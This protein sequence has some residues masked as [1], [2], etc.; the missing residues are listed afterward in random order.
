MSPCALQHMLHS[1]LLLHCFHATAV[2][3][4]G[5]RVATTVVGPAVPA[6][7][8]PR[9]WR[10]ATR[11]LT[12]VAPEWRSATHLGWPNATLAQFLGGGLQQPDSCWISGRD[13][14][15]A[16]SALPPVDASTRKSWCN[17]PNFDAICRSSGDTST[18]GL[19]AAMLDIR[20]R[21]R[22]GDIGSTAIRK[23]APE[24]MGVTVGISSL[25]AR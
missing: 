18:S 13:G 21:S 17:R 25:T 12:E 23:F 6:A 7:I 9:W 20:E 1:P 10:C 8:P 24:N 3:C 11:P 15:R 5:G 2:P 19:L 16:T 4:S 22:S 14:R